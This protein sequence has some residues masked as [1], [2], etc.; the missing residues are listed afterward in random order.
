MAKNKN[1]ILNVKNEKA[2]KLKP[3]WLNKNHGLSKQCIHK[4][5]KSAA[6]KIF[7]KRRCP[8]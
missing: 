8:L 5:K 4:K 6:I 3:I 2:N 7:E 1:D